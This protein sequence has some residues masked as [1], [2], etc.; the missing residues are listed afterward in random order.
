[1]AQLE[2]PLPELVAE[3]LKRGW[4]RFEFVAAAKEW[5]AEK[6]LTVI[7]TLLRGKLIDYYMEFDDA[8]NGDLKLLKAAL[9]ERAGKKEDPLVASKKFNLRSQSPGEKVADFASSLKQLFKSSYPGEVMTSTVLLQRFLTGLRPE[10]S[11]QLLL[12]QKPTTFT[13]ALKDARDIE[14]ALEFGG[15]D[16]NV[17]AVGQNQRT[18][19]ASNT[20]AL[21]DTL[22]KRL[23]SLEL[24]VQK[25]Q[26]QPRQA[27]RPTY[28]RSQ[29]QYRNCRIG[30]CYNC[31]EEGHLRRDCPLNY[32]RPA[33]KVDDRWPRNP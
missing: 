7:P 18:T 32:Y 20:A 19:E 22:T 2:L 6:Q 3:D 14:Y 13:A 28:A 27:E 16:D 21:L 26:M 4:T 24:A 11:R 10:I 5:S 17:H 12:H 9:E 8:V 33:P 30:P 25:T 1:M 15:E 31:G 23:E 29:G